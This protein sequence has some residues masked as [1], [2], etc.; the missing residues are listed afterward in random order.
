MTSHTQSPEN[1]AS[2]AVKSQCVEVV[3]FLSLQ[4]EIPLSTCHV[5]CTDGAFQTPLNTFLDLILADWRHGVQALSE[6]GRQIDFSRV[7]S[8]AAKLQH[9]LVVR[10]AEDHVVTNHFLQQEVE[11]GSDLAMCLRKGVCL[12][13]MCAEVHRGQVHL[14]L[15]KQ[16]KADWW[17][18]L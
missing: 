13:D 8:S 2:G 7:T 10:H 12:E 11:E 14:Q 17:V 3:G 15:A 6:Q 18:Q 1:C 16:R 5:H 9:T 4:W